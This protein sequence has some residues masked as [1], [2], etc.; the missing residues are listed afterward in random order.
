MSSP[1]HPEQA[2]M[3][4]LVERQMR[5][6]ELTR[7]QRETDA[8]LATRPVQ[9]FIC[10][11]RQEGVQGGEVAHALG[12]A[13][14]WP[15]F[16]REILRTMAGDD[17][18]R[19]R[20]Y[21]S[22]DERDMTWWEESLRSI[23]QP[24]FGRNDY[25]RRLGETILSLA[26]QG[27]SV[28]LGRGAD[29]LLPAGEGL[30]VRLVAPSAMRVADYAQARG[31]SHDEALTQITQVEAEREAFIRKHFG[32]DVNDSARSDLIINLAHFTVQQATELILAARALR[33]AR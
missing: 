27:S 7:A 5:N 13:L 19:E 1:R 33:G 30:R 16:D 21:A 25:F 31:V 4:K 24:E 8:R 29:L 2:A 20:V 15:V 26:R 23:T 17:A 10:I 11:S 12:K 3:T 14:H 22:M 28:F 18:L 9:D 32:V 6:W